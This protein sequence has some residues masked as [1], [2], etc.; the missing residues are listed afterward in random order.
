MST[1]IRGLIDRLQ[2]QSAME[3]SAA[4]D[5]LMHMGKHADAAAVALVRACG[6]DSEEVRECAIAALEGMGPPREE[7]ISHFVEL[8]RDDQSAVGYWAATL[9]GRLTERATPAVSSLAS[10]LGDAHSDTVRERCAWAL[11]EIGPGASNAVLALQSVSS[12]D[13]R[14]SRL[15]SRALDQI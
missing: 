6:D 15:A 12:G 9:L 5:E 10:G 14:L 2:A 1:Q 3:R 7:D 4:A 13:S 11:G 8:L